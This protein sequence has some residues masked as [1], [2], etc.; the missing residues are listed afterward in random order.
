MCTQCINRSQ[1]PAAISQ[2]IAHCQHFC[3]LSAECYAVG[4]TPR[5]ID[6][7]IACSLT[8]WVPQRGPLDTFAVLIKQHF[9]TGRASDPAASSK[10][11]ALTHVL[12]LCISFPCPCFAW[13][14]ET[15][16][17]KL[18]CLKASLFTVHSLSHAVLTSA[19]SVTTCVESDQVHGCSCQFQT[20][21]NCVNSLNICLCVCVHA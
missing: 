17:P 1:S 2:C 5:E 6:S 21:L 7:R 12:G 15:C 13:R 20:G 11:P 8:W 3:S 9:G 14:P 18:S 4:K 19:C 10:P 16:N